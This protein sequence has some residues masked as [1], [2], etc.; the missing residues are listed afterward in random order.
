MASFLCLQHSYSSV[1]CFTPF[2]PANP[3][4]SSQRATQSEDEVCS[5]H[6]C[7]FQIYPWLTRTWRSR[8]PWWSPGNCSRCPLLTGKNSHSHRGIL[9]RST[10]PRGYS[11]VSAEFIQVWS[12]C[13]R[14]F[15]RLG[16]SRGW[17]KSQ[18]IMCLVWF[19]ALL[20]F[21]KY[22]TLSLSN[23]YPF[24]RLVGP[25]K[26]IGTT[27][28]PL[29]FQDSTPLLPLI[30]ILLLLLLSPLSAHPLCFPM[31]LFSQSCHLLP[32]VTTSRSLFIT[33][34]RLR[35]TTL[36]KRPWMINF[37]LMMTV[38]VTRYMNIY[39]KRYSTIIL[40]NKASAHNLTDGYILR[41]HF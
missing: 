13:Y 40:C 6:R 38:S 35:S 23:Q 20:E 14:V 27:N 28:S 18:T 36:P 22:E 2:K 39:L 21:S 15:R 5:I 24:T 41:Q 7:P 9:Q 32:L 25:E 4:F 16:P 33:L 17:K 29:L 19:A 37:T 34:S 12:D 3:T 10:I 30:Y 31:Y 11:E 8:G 26:S 1:S